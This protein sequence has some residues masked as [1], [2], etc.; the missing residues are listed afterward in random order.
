MAQLAAGRSGG[1]G[2]GATHDSCPIAEHDG[3][4]ACLSDEGGG[5]YELGEHDLT[6]RGV[7]KRERGEIEINKARGAG[8]SCG[9]GSL[10]LQDCTQ[11]KFRRRR[12][13]WQLTGKC[14]S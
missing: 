8:G 13:R 14:E 4:C 11:A 7:G 6:E 10:E 3:C 5:K 1:T 2:A 9:G 12:A